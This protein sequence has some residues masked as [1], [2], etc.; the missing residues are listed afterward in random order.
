M[1]KIKATPPRSTAQSA[2]AKPVKLP[3][4]KSSVGGAA[5]KAAGN[6]AVRNQMLG[7]ASE[8]K[9]QGKVPSIPMSHK[10]VQAMQKWSY[11]TFGGLRRR[12]NKELAE[13]PVF[14]A[15][16]LGTKK[17]LAEMRKGRN[18]G[19]PLSGQL[20]KRK[21]MEYDHLRERREG[22]DPANPNNLRLK[23]PKAHKGK[24]SYKANK[25]FGSPAS[26]SANLKPPSPVTK[27]KAVKPAAP[28]KQTKSPM[29]FFKGLKKP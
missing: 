17:N 15:S 18:P 19:S 28:V 21:K 6:A 12:L 27:P 13:D 24:I 1:S 23:T 26:S 3:A 16:K 2:P 14:R 29:S 7:G 25:A 11:K 22:I 9:P 20:G 8:S 4:A 10:L 5:R